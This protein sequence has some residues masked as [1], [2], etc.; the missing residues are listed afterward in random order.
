MLLPT[1]LRTTDTERRHCSWPPATEIPISCEN[2]W[3]KNLLFWHLPECDLHI[4]AQRRFMALTRNKHSFPALFASM[5]TQIKQKWCKIALYILS[6][7]WGIVF[8]HITPPTHVLLK[9]RSKNERKYRFSLT[10]WSYCRK[11]L[12]VASMPVEASRNFFVS[13]ARMWK[14]LDEITGQRRAEEAG[15]SGINWL[16]VL[17]VASTGVYIDILRQHLKRAPER[18]HNYRASLLKREMLALRNAKS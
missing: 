12:R 9:L 14:I 17:L 1:Q 11:L 13:C 6:V 18:E 15:N 7:R 16:E 10:H 3:C 2:C 4:W 8:R 5:P